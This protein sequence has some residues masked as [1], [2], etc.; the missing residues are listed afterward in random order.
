MSQEKKEKIIKELREIAKPKTLHM[1]TELQVAVFFKQFFDLPYT[2][3][4]T[5]AAYAMMEVAQKGSYYPFGEHLAKLVTKYTCPW[6]CKFHRTE[7]HDACFDEAC[8]AALHKNQTD[9]EHQARFKKS[10]EEFKEAL[11]WDWKAE[12]TSDTYDADCQALFDGNFVLPDE[13]KESDDDEE[14]LDIDPL[15]DPRD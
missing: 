4:G 9:M 6:C 12:L 2:V 14:F 1:S 10:K 13:Y 3:E 11:E 15:N 5:A 7:D 8:S